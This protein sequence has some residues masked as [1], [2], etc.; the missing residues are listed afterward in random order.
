MIIIIV[1]SQSASC[2][3]LKRFWYH[4]HKWPLKMSN[5]ILEALNTLGIK[6]KMEIEEGD[7]DLTES[8]K[9]GFTKAHQGIF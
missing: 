7:I 3:L 8:F 1:E 4:E 5:S 2:Q 9:D 6:H